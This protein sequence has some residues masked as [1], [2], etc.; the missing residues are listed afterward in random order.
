MRD[1]GLKNFHNQ[2]AYRIVATAGSQSPSYICEVCTWE[3]V[4]SA[5]RAANR[6]LA[7]R[8]FLDGRRQSRW[9]GCS[10]TKPSSTE[11]GKAPTGLL[12]RACLTGSRADVDSANGGSNDAVALRALNGTEWAEMGVEKQ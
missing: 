3:A 12:A 1:D 10:C 11:K 8:L 2:R 9:V 6:P 5:H 4:C 7:D